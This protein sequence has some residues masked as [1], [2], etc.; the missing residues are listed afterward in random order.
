[1]RNKKHACIYVHW[2]RSVARSR[3]SLKPCARAITSVLMP[4]SRLHHKLTMYV[5][6][7]TYIRDH[8][9]MH[10][11]TRSY[12]EAACMCAA[13]GCFACS[14]SSNTCP[15]LVLLNLGSVVHAHSA[16]Q[17]GCVKVQVLMCAQPTHVRTYMDMELCVCNQCANACMYTS[18]CIQTNVHTYTC[19]LSHACYMPDPH[20]HK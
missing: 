13:A 17:S 8:V 6:M 3:E 9:H 10:A 1:V 2:Q 19:S 4:R 5:C 14:F 18:T 12:H 11:Y 7:H 20:K 15:E 16:S